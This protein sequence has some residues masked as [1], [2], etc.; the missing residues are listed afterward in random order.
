MKIPAIAMFI[1]FTSG[2]VDAQIDVSG[3]GS[4]AYVK[5]E[6]GQSQYVFNAG[7]PTF[8]WRWD[9]FAD[10]RINNSVTL[11]SNVRMLQDQVLHI[12]YFAL[13]VAD[14]GSSG[15][16]AQLGLIDLPVG[17]LG[18]R[19]F[20]KD[21]PFFDLP[22]MN[23]HYTS[24]CASDYRL[25]VLV[26]EF[27]IHGDGVRLLDQGL[28][29]LGVKLYGSFGIFDYAAALTNG[30]VSETSTYGPN[31]LNANGGFGKMFRLAVTPMTGLTIGGSYAAGPFMM[32]Q[33]TD[34][35]SS[36]Y[37]EDA[38]NY[39]QEIFTGDID[40]SFDH[41]AFYGQAAYN[42][43]KFSE[44]A[45]GESSGEWKGAIHSDL[46][47]FAYSFEGRYAITPRLSFAARV[48]GLV[49]ATVA[50]SVYS[51][52]GTVWYNGTWDHNVLRLES[53]FGYRLSREFLVKCVYEWNTTYDL[54][55]DPKD[56]FFAIQTVV[57]F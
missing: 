28:Y 34:T 13:N 51:H 52:E 53:A 14:I 48:G 6:N 36:M 21:N 22:L 17:S 54:S 24:L 29:D 42:V 2:L 10:M 18:T 12:D 57:S 46:K 27:A 33:S 47:A 37:G 23:E 49:F 31:G 43:W 5:S 41:V 15:V 16:N 40:F 8:A 30:M 3:Q 32:D 44:D 1:L 26:P 4:V 50:E 56:N 7:N 20:P 9:L 38:R 55:E 45:G 19:R 11:F 35:N 25:W 39:P